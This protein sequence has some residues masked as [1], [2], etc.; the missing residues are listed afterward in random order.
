MSFLNPWLFVGLV[1]LVGVPLLIHILNLRFPKLF[2]FS[3]LEYL[4]VA[5]V[6][7]SW[8]YRWRHWIMMLV[9]TLLILLLFL[10][11]LKPVID[12]YGA[13]QSGSGVRFVLLILDYS[14]SM[15][16]R[17][18]SVT[19]REKAVYEARKLIDSLSVDDRV[20]II[21]AGAAPKLCFPE[22]SQNHSEAKQFL[23]SIKPSYTHA[24]FNMANGQAARLLAKATGKREVCY[25]SDFQRKNWM[26]VD[27]AA[28]PGDTR[29]FFIDTG[30]ANK[31]NHA[32][33]GVATSQSQVLTGNQVALEISIA[34]YSDLDL[35]DKVKV[36]IDQEQGYEKEFQAAPWQVAKVILNVP[37]GLPGLRR[38][39]VQISSDVLTADDRF[40][41]TLPVQEKEE[42]LVISDQ[43][44]TKHDAVRFLKTALNP[45]DQMAGSLLPR[46]IASKQ[47]TAEQLA[48]VKIL[49]ITQI[50]VLSEAA[51]QII[52]RH[53][54]QGAGIVYFA[55]GAL[56]AGNLTRLERFIGPGTMPIQLSTKR[57]AD[58]IASGAQQVIRGDFKSPYLK[59]F[60]GAQRQ[61]LALMEFYDFYYASSTGAGKVLLWY[62]DDTPAMG[63]LEHGLGTLLILNFSAS[64]IS[65][66]LARQRAFPAWIQ[67]LVRTLSGRDVRAQ[68]YAIGQTIQT[69]IWKN[70]LKDRDI[71]A[72]DGSPVTVKKELNADRFSVVFT[73][74]QLG[75][76]T[77]RTSHSIQAYGINPNP[78]ESDLRSISQEALPQK[79]EG[80]E[81]THF[82]SGTEDY[83]A[84]NVGKPVF[85]Y[86]IIAASA[87]L[88]LELLL[89]MI[90]RWLSYAKI[91]PRK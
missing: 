9:R 25:F 54:L 20:N 75:F 66:N 63:S 74:D 10:A 72:P 2:Q 52:A 81:Q 41:F 90:F 78:D 43:A 18:D 77:L 11:F 79:T 16:Y 13:L 71:Q 84:L 6:Q 4:R 33:I 24:D 86:F 51:C 49:F 36:I 88:A 69:E 67:D 55:D 61:N 73:P 35:R 44:E 76:Y 28:L 64:E 1:P 70:D 12:Q 82:I 42:V 29:L 26:H 38:G 8:F 14:M 17:G 60:R 39:Q 59:L 37:A 21:L 57:I 68:S 56:D 22:F 58:N 65:S 45:Y 53:L 3:T 89:Q 40:F 50:D 34:N 5:I 80:G 83:Q 46:Q 62:A 7:R 27:F 47:I 31:A 85:H 87:V 91:D 15:E 30:S 32:I 48:G 19:C 23:D